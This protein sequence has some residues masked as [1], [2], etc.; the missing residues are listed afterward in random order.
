MKKTLLV[1][2]AFFGLAVNAQTLTYANHA[3][4]WYNLPYQIMQCDSTG[5]T[6]GASGAAQ[7]WTYNPINMHGLKTYSTT[8]TNPT[9][10]FYPATNVAVYSSTTDVSYYNTN[11]S[12][13]KYYGG[14]LVINSYAISAI[15]ASPAIYAVYPMSLNTSTTSTTNGTVTISGFSQNF[16]GSCMVKADATGTLV[17]P[18][19]TFTDVIRV[20]TTQTLTA[21][22]ATVYLSNYDYYSISASKAPLFSIQTSTINAIAQPT[23]TQTVVYVQPNYSVVGVTESSKTDIQLTVFPNPTSSFINFST[24]SLEASK[25]MVYDLTGKMMAT[26]M[27]E[28]GKSKMNAG[29]FAGGVYMYLISDKNNQVLTTGKFTVSK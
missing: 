15:Y 21:S 19:K 17:L 3:P 25:V 16:T 8:N 7:T 5:V 13:N 26:E 28:N 4:A 23:S 24:A 22:I 11:A 12:T 20:V 10:P 29:N 2:F 9:N 6:S 18:G 14:D 1:I 27:I